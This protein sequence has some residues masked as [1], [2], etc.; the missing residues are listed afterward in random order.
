MPVEVMSTLVKVPAEVTIPLAQHVV[1]VGWSKLQVLP[2]C[3]VL[4]F[5]HCTCKQLVEQHPKTVTVWLQFVVS[6]HPSIIDQLSVMLTW[7]QTPFVTKPDGVTKMLV[8]VPG[9]LL[10][11]QVETMG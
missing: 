4:S 11:Q 3:I 6:P 9:T 8:V 1:A 7:G 2:H 10:R 5:G